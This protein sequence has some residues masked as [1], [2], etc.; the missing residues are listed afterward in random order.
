MLTELENI[1]NQLRDAESL[2]RQAIE[3]VNHSNPKNNY[4]ALCSRIQ[5]IHGE[6]EGLRERMN[7]LNSL[8]SVCFLFFLFTNTDTPS[9]PIN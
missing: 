9:T 6:I 8:K 5:T 4:L 3:H 2:V 7:V 1:Q